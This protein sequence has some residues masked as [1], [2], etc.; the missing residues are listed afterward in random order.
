MPPF[1][2]VSSPCKLYFL[3]EFVWICRVVL[4]GEEVRRVVLGVGS[5][6][7]VQSIRFPGQD[8]GND[9][10]TSHTGKTQL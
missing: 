10:T 9:D 3:Q 7:P 4:H 5:M 8:L 6:V 1:R 2:P